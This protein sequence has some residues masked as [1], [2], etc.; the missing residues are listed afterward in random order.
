MFS[1][2]QLDEDAVR[3]AM[4]S[5]KHT[6]HERIRAHCLYLRSKQYTIME[7]SDILDIT[8]R[9]VINIT[10]NYRE[11]GL[12]KAVK[13][14]PRPGRPREIDDRMKS[15]VVALICSDPPEGFD[16][17]TLELLQKHVVQNAIVD[18]ISKES[19]RLILKEHDLKPW[20]HKMWCV[21]QI[22]EEYTERME[23]IL[24]LYE[25]PYSKQ[26]PMVC[27]DEKPVT[28]QSDKREPIKAKPGSVEKI[29]HE[30]ERHGSINVFAM[31]EPKVGK[32][33]NKVTELKA[34]DDF[35]EFLADVK[36]YYRDVDRV[37]LVMDNY[38]THNKNS[39]VKRFGE[40]KASE[41]WSHFEVHYTPVHGSWLNQA[42]IAIGMYQRQCLGD[43]RIPDIA[44]LEKKTLAWNRA[45]NQKGVV[46][47]WKFNKESARKK[48]GYG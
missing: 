48:F 11:G 43:C 40:E 31:V 29:D 32:Y 47:K 13:D 5:S 45:I 2:S 15:E 28:L 34:G 16:R 3:I 21:G 33:I 35:A 14:D 9:T 39:L 42:E 24:D 22:D 25:E 27:I 19:L 23:D 46:I 18:G 17:W 1:L 7:A 12:T 8:P 36:D 6:V 20:Q 44:T 26:K 30:Y 10:Q 4:K 37:D 38:C 41:I